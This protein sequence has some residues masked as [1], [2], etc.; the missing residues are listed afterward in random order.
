M[1]SRRDW[2]P[3]LPIA[4]SPNRRPKARPASR[5]GLGDQR[6]QRLLLT[7][8]QSPIVQYPDQEVARAEHCLDEQRQR[9]DKRIV[10][11]LDWGQHGEQVEPALADHLQA[12]E[13]HLPKLVH[14]AGWMVEPIR[15]LKLDEGGA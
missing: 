12:R 14:P 4:I 10:R 1:R 6:L 13:G 9:V 5:W 2:D 3:E 15:S 11:L 7:R 8:L